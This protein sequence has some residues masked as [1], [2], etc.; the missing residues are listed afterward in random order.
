MTCVL[1]LFSDPG[2]P[3]KDVAKPD[4]PGR[5]N[6]IQVDWPFW[7]EQANESLVAMEMVEAD[8]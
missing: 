4:R 8:D 6:G 5:R 3:T 1:N 7:C 2:N